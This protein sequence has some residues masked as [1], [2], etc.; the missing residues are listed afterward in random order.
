MPEM[1]N[2]RMPPDLHR[3]ATARAPCDRGRTMVPVRLTAANMARHGTADRAVTA[4]GERGERIEK[5]ARLYQ[6]KDVSGPHSD[7]RRFISPAFRDLDRED[8][9]AVMRCW[10]TIFPCTS[11][12]VTATGT[13]VFVASTS[14]RS[15]TLFAGSGRFMACS[16]VR[17][18][19][20]GNGEPGRAARA[21]LLPELP[22]VEAE[23]DF[24]IASLV[25]ALRQQ[26]FDVRLHGR[27]RDRLHA[28]LPSR[29]E[30]DVGR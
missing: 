30:L 12:T 8:R 1:R 2:T 20:H 7:G 25:K 5:L 26:G 14:T 29:A 15:P 13:W 18:W 17:R 27:P 11:I 9:S 4:A 6:R 19:V 10:R 3:G 21:S 28:S 22:Q 23:A 16:F 24:H